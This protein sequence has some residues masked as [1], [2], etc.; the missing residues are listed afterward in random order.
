MGFAIGALI[1]S[2]LPQ[3]DDRLLSTQT[4]DPTACSSTP[5]YSLPALLLL[6]TRVGCLVSRC[7]CCICRNLTLPR[8]VQHRR[9]GALY[10]V[11][12]FSRDHASR[13]V[14]IPL[15]SCH[16]RLT[17]H[18]RCGSPFSVH[19]GSQL[20]CSTPCRSQRGHRPPTYCT[21]GR[22]HSIHPVCD[23]V[24]MCASDA[25]AA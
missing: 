20:D 18:C 3:S 7:L 10:G 24:S 12:V 6:F 9:Y 13:Y 17:C 1:V 11:G 16:M 19:A 23:W 25:A 5:W 4:W 14:P 22:V 15:F 8:S 21:C 2:L